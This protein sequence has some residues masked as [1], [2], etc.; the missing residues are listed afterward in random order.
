MVDCNHWGNILHY[1][2]R[3]CKRITRSEV[4]SEQPALESEFDQAFVVKKLMDEILGKNFRLNACIDSK[5]TFSCM[6][7]FLSTLEKRLQTDASALCGSHVR[8]Q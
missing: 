1:S 8:G 5:T 2:C 6:A 3:K 4:A 7:R